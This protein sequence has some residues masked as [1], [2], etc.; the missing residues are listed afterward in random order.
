MEAQEKLCRECTRNRRLMEQ[1]WQTVSNEY[2]DNEGSFSEA[3]WS[4][5]LYRT[6][7][8]AGGLLHTKAETYD[9][10]LQLR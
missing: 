7:N 10:S 9:Q 6:L 1:V 5:E 2:Y 3:Q 4:G 8:K